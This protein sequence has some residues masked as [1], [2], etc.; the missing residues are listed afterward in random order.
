MTPE[1]G[2]GRSPP[3]SAPVKLAR[4]PDRLVVNPDVTFVVIPAATST[5]APRSLGTNTSPVFAAC[6]NVAARC[7]ARSTL[8]RSARISFAAACAR[9]V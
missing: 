1:G 9:V 8:A 2:T 3:N 4:L 7:R 5:N 6:S